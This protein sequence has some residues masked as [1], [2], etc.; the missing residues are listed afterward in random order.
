[1]VHRAESRVQWGVHCSNSCVP[2]FYSLLC[3]P[4]FK[5]S[6]AL[7]FEQTVVPCWRRC[8][9]SHLLSRNHGPGA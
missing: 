3:N 6:A 7:H 1:M 8:R 4:L 9:Q 5:H 2:T